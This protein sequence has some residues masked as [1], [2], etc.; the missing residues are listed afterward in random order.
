[1]ELSFG[2]GTYRRD[3]GQFPPFRQVNM[4]LEE[5]AT[6][7]KKYNLMTRPPLVAYYTW[8]SSN[9]V[10]G[11]FQKSGL[12]GGAFFAVIGGT[13]YK[14]GV[15]LG[16]INGSG[17][18]RWAGGTGELVLTRGQSA[19]SY[20]GTNLQAI[21]MPGGF[22]VASV[23]WMNGWFVFV[24][25]GSGRWYWSARNDG[26]TVDAL[27]FATAEGTTDNLLDILRQ[28]DVFWMMGADSG[29][30]WVLSGD[31]DLPWTKVSQRTLPNGIQA[32]GCGAEIYGAVYYISSDGMVCMV[33][34]QMQRV[35][36]SSLEERIRQST[37]GLAFWYTYEGKTLFCARLDSGT[38]A[39]DIG[40]GH[41]PVEF[42]TYGR[43]N[44][45]PK[46][47]VNVGSEPLFGDDTANTIWIFEPTFAAATDSGNAE[48]PRLFSAGLPLNEQPMPISN[49]L[50]NGDNGS[51][52]Q[53]AGAAAEPM[54]E[55]RFSRDG[56]REWG[57]PK[58]AKWGRQGEYKRQAR[59][60]GCGS[61]NPPGFL[62]EFTMNE[63]APLRVA[64]VR[65]N[66]SLAG[67]G[68]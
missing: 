55:M 15:S 56:G 7:P 5:T 8:G 60:G 35:S 1:M 3:R 2:R 36:D 48:F 63:C 28:G 32:T 65:V 26:R 37:T 9:P 17:P 24:R 16:A 21:A 14:D 54:L 31:P 19:Y 50:V 33:A 58:V 4:L 20:N 43:T 42:Q 53:L 45:A 52:A 39:L 25:S 27:S 40:L 22:N 11:V 44:W 6:D 38:F 34:D 29:E 46:C 41:Q 59:F 57:T 10:H 61:F 30:A 51:A 67:R 49:V 47:A 64:N 62:A 68:R 13:L 12:F 66:E 23:N 18:V